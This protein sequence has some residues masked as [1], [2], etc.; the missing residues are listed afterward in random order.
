MIDRHRLGTRALALVQRR[1]KAVHVI[2]VWKLDECLPVQ[3]LDAT[4]R[5]GCVVA[6]QACAN[7]I[8]DSRRDTPQPG[9]ESPGSDAC[10][11]SR[12]CGTRV[13]RSKEAQDV[14]GVIL[15]VAIESRYPLCPSGP[16]AGC[17]RRALPRPARVAQEPH[18]SD[19]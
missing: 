16:D 6:Q 4:P 7:T 2:E 11:E 19:A 18:F 1:K 3:Q 17:E 13:P 8:G 5:I 15:A 9:V 14:S 10:N 12:I